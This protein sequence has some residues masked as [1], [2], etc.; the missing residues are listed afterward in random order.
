MCSN[1]TQRCEQ[2]IHNSIHTH[3]S[4]SLLN[5]SIFSFNLL[6]LLYMP[7]KLYTIHR[8]YSTYTHFVDKFLLIYTHLIHLTPPP[9]ALPLCKLSYTYI[10]SLYC[11]NK[12]TP[13]NLLAPERMYGRSQA[14]PNQK[15]YPY[16]KRD[17][18]KATSYF[19]PHIARSKSHLLST[20]CWSSSTFS[21]SFTI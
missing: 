10:L 2:L 1:Y 4:I 5:M 8:F 7:I 11:L 12:P 18:L 14:I 13:I 15:I 17:C 3:Y 19:S 20:S 9:S 16:T 6:Y 21:A